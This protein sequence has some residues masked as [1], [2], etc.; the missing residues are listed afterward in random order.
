MVNGLERLG[1]RF[2]TSHRRE[3]GGAAG[4]S[5]AASSCFTFL[6]LLLAACAG[7][8]FGVSYLGESIDYGSIGPDILCGISVRFMHSATLVIVP[9]ST[10]R[11]IVEERDRDNTLELFA[12]HGPFARADH[13]QR[14]P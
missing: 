3:E 4:G 1:D 11:S 13:P 5:R 10:F 12:D 7:S 9:F 14:R 8:I 6:L 2:D